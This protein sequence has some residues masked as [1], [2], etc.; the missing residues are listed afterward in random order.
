V[1]TL[2]HTGLAT[3]SVFGTKRGDMPDHSCPTRR[4]VV[5]ATWVA[6]QAAIPAAAQNLT[7]AI[8]G[9]VTDQSGA[10]VSGATVTV[11]SPQLITARETRVTSE[12]GGYRVPSL[13]PGIYAVTFESAGFQTLKREGIVLLAGQSLAVDAQLEVAQ[14]AEALTVSGAP[15]LID[16]RSAALVNTSA[17]ATLENIPV[18][19]E[20]TKLLNIMPGATDGRYEFAPIN[21]VHGGSVR[22][23]QYNL[24]GANLT[25]PSDNATI[26][27]L[28]VDALQEIQT[29]TA[30]IPAEFGDA[31]GALVNYVTKSGGNTFSG[32]GNLFYQ[33]E[34]TQSDNVDGNLRQQGLTS[35]GGYEHFYDTGVLLG[36]PLRRN[37]AWFFVNFRDQDFATRKPDFRAPIGTDEQQLFTK[38][39]VQVSRDNRAELGYLYRDYLE[40]PFGAASTFRNSDDERTWDANAKTNYLFNPRW[41]TVLSHN[42]FVE[43]RATFSIYK[44]L[45]QSPNN[46]GSPHFMDLVTGIISGG[47]AQPDG[48][49]RWNRHEAEVDLTHFVEKGFMGSHNL[50][51]GFRWG[52]TPFWFTH[53]LKGARGDSP[54]ELVGCSSRCISETPGVQHLLFGG[55]PFRVRLYNSPAKLNYE[56]RMWTYYAQDQWVF[57]NRVTI[58]GGVRIDHTTADVLESQSGGGRWDP[59]RIFPAREGLIDITNWAPRF[60]FV[61]DVSDDHRTAVKA[62]AG[63]FYAQ[64]IVGF[65]LRANGAFMGYREFDWADPNGNRV[66]DVGEE[67][68][69]R[70]DTRPNPNLIPTV[71]PDLKNQYTDVYTIGIE[72]EMAPNLSLSVTGIFK[73]DGDLTGLVNNAVPFSAYNRITVTN[74][75]TTQP[76]EIFTLRPEFLGRPGQLVLTNPGERPGDTEKLVR[77]YDGLEVVLRR[78]YVDRWLLETSYVW[79]RGK[80]NVNNHYGGSLFADYTNPNF[81]VNRYGDLT[82][83]PRHQ[84][85]MYGTYRAPLAIYVSGYFEALS[86]IPLTD[87]YT[88]INPNGVRGA[89]TVRFLQRDFPQILSEAFIDVAGEPAG[90]RKFDAQTRL[91][92]RAEK[93]FKIKRGDISVIVDVF[94]VLNANTVIRVND[95]RLDSPQFL[96]PAEIVGPRQARFGVRWAF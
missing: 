61:W 11:Q 43:G 30:G 84:F 76:L 55:D 23:N 26:V 36:G 50:K 34:G 63:R 37:R 2:G 5:V 79:G 74:P 95:L 40:F 64:I 3:A 62:S 42:T 93:R 15:P 65:T 9:T 10:R 67:G 85:K 12:Q 22:Q 39:T 92:L 29:T 13:P 53:L 82:L 4:I 91:D 6:L 21:T 69:L 70:A 35:A 71:D 48:D 73:R 49:N 45:A 59:L 14:I 83:G 8:F 33:G 87:S 17:Q 77:Q 27:T 16:T 1:S 81:L 20:F 72:R 68:T 41:R 80:G 28:P 90:T 47:S 31:S 66:Y 60:G 46:D 52:I 96:R 19:R 86:G 89:A 57:R 88:F 56:N 38:A 58:N 44:I 24:D 78:R 32:G 94:N 51:T 18:P 25:N 75:L 54:L 7:G